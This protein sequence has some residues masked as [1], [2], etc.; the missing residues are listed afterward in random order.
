MAG[1]TLLTSC[2]RPAERYR[3][4]AVNEFSVFGVQA[5]ASLLAGPAVHSLGWTQLNLAT[6][7]L[8]VVL[9]VVLL[10]RSPTPSGAPSAASLSGRGT[11]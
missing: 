2:Y 10:L 11:R 8:L 7:P 1:T 6:V 9:G 5:I 4:Q 3:A